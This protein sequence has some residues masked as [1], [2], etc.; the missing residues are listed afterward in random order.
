M[1]INI[2]LIPKERN[3]TARSA[4]L[5]SLMKLEEIIVTYYFVSLTVS[6]ERRK[7]GSAIIYD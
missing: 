2:N 4:F 1:Y 5:D 3:E 7:V 6:R